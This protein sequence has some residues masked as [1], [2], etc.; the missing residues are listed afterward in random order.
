MVLSLVMTAAWAQT[1]MRVDNVFFQTDLQQ[2]L[3][4]IAAQSGEN[5]IAGPDVQGIVSVTLDNVTVKQALE[6]VLAGTRY[7]VVRQP[8]YYLVFDADQMSAAFADVA[9]TRLVDLTHL[10]PNS[11]LSLLVEPL[12]RY[13]RVDDGAGKLAVTA[14]PELLGRII[15]DLRRLD[16]P[17]SRNTSL[18][19]LQHV[20]ASNARELLPPDLQRFVRVDPDRNTLAITAPDEKRLTRSPCCVASISP[21]VRAR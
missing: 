4:D 21:A 7:D 3:E 20:A 14:P 17:G 2:A 18:Y 1:D 8:D 9:E 19:A 16:V 13:V 12:R 15:A 5:I 10:T 6:L 11:A